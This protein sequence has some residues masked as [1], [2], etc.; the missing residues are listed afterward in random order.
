MTLLKSLPLGLTSPDA[1]VL[2]SFWMWHTACLQEIL[3]MV[4]QS[5]NEDFG[6]ISQYTSWLIL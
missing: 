4:E 6:A 3:I 2:Q 5:E 1:V